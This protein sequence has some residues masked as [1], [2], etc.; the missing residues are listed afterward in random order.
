LVNGLQSKL[1]STISKEPAQKH[2]LSGT[3]LPTTTSQAEV[4]IEAI[5]HEQGNKTEAK[6]SSADSGI[7]TN[8]KPAQE[9]SQGESQAL[10]ANPKP[11]DPSS[12]EPQS[13]TAAPA[14]VP[15]VTPSKP[16]MPATSATAISI[17]EP[18]VRKPSNPA[19]TG[20]NKTT[21]GNRKAS[22]AP[23]ASEKLTFAQKLASKIAK[24]KKEEEGR[25]KSKSENRAKKAFKTISVIMGAFVLCWTP[26]HIL[27]LV[28]GFCLYGGTSC[29]N[30]HLYMFSYFLCYSNSPINPFCY[31]LANQHFK[32]TFYRL[33]KGDFHVT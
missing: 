22:E 18:S 7:D 14:P 11:A 28:E 3:V 17:I 23:S 15:A 27:A 9:S 2:P 33:L 12:T 30:T 21:A 20:A 4:V 13:S 16:S 26:Y 5:V 32:K 10:L 19:T 1:E 8:E 29:I 6:D 31:A 24:N 25:K